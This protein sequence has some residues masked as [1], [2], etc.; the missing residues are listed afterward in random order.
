L[1]MKF[2]SSQRKDSTPKQ[3]TYS[4]YLKE[5]KPFYRSTV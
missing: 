2:E 1:K 3:I 5:L 4:G